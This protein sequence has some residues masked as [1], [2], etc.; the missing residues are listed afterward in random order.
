M[1]KSICFVIVCLMTVSVYAQELKLKPKMCAVFK[2]GVGMFVE[3]GEAN[4]SGG[5]PYVWL[6]EIPPVSHGSLWI[7]TYDKEAK[8]DEVVALREDEK[9]DALTLN[10]LLM[11]NVGKKVK[12]LWGEK[13]IAGTIVSVPEPEKKAAPSSYNYGYASYPSIVNID[14]GKGM[15]SMNISAITVAEFPEGFNKT[16]T[17]SQGK[18]K[19]RIKVATAKTSAKLGM[20][21]LQKGITWAPSYLIEISDAKKAKLIMSATVVNDAA[22]FEGADLFFVVGFPNFLFQDV[23]SPLALDADVGQF[24]NT[25]SNRSTG[26]TGPMTNVMAQ[27]AMPYSESEPVS[28]PSYSASSAGNL[29]GETAEDLFFYEMKNSTLKKG[30]RAY[31]TVFSADV[32]YK[33]I[34]EWDIPGTAMK[35]SSS[36]S[37][38]NEDSVSPDTDEKVWHSLKLTNT[39]DVPWTTAPAMTVKSFRALGQDIL[40]Y[41]PKGAATNVKITVAPDIKVKRVENEKERKTN[42]ITQYGYS[43]DLVTVE[44]KLTLKNYKNQSVT[45]DITKRISGAVASASDGGKTEKLAEALKSLNPS[46]RITWELPLKA[47]EEK[48]ITYSYKIYIRT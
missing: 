46:S 14:T 2:N 17:Q 25:L 47:G 31:Y 28:T 48:T 12:I 21:F 29:G 10:E 35:S 9:R 11:S 24:L 19:L 23:V 1:R 36:Y 7:L 16:F 5:S 22:D 43:Y 39:T 37:Y 44:G 40:N 42:A 3:D 38:A 27:S 33:H 18:R 41:T 4:L 15:V 13:E 8:V 6:N 30:A 34:Y 45:M 32:D 20:S 26:Y